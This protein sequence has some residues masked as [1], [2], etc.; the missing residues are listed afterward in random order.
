[1]IENKTPMQT[2]VVND[3]GYIALLWFWAAIDEPVYVNTP[4]FSSDDVVMI[5]ILETNIVHIGSD[6]YGQVRE[7]SLRIRYGQLKAAAVIEDARWGLHSAINWKGRRQPG[8]FDKGFYF[9]FDAAPPTEFGSIYIM[10]I[11]K[12]FREQ[13]TLAPDTYSAKGLLLQPTGVL[14]GQYR[15]LGVFELHNSHCG[16]SEII[17]ALPGLSA[18]EAYDE[19]LPPDENGNKYIITLV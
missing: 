17:D 19:I 3:I 7:A 9:K 2:L 11:Y 16:P 14:R 8:E 10:L 12:H 15:R 4:Y 13:N 6:C 1:M 18:E 5:S